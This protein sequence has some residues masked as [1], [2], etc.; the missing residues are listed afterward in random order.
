MVSVT[1]F[2]CAVESGSLDS[3]HLPPW[4][5]HSMYRSLQKDASSPFNCLGRQFNFWFLRSHLGIF[6]NSVTTQDRL[7]PPPIPSTRTAAFYSS[8]VWANI[9]HSQGH[10]GW[11][12][13]FQRR[14]A[15]AG[16][17]A[18]RLA[19]G[20]SRKSAGLWQGG[21]C[22]ALRTPYFLKVRLKKKEER[23]NLLLRP[24]P[25]FP[26]LQT[27]HHNECCS[28]V[29][30][31]SST[32]HLFWRFSTSPKAPLNSIRKWSHYT[33]PILCRRGFCQTVFPPPW[34]WE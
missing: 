1:I 17:S 24:A 31:R 20:E 7:P 14:D 4:A 21:R 3:L 10:L 25:V 18:W 26:F 16:F 28:G 23:G 2:K 8:Q 9:S 13:G 19:R 12:Y 34:F 32:P 29:W 22:S 15:G 33:W 11:T 27:A 30:R 6:L 5:R